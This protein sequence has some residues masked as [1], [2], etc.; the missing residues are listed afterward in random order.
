MTHGAYVCV[1]PRSAAEIPALVAWLGLHNEFG[2]NSRT[3]TYALLRR[4]SAK[5]ADIADDA[6]L[7]ADAIVHVE[8]PDAPRVE[9]F[10]AAFD[11]AR[12]L[13]GAIPPMQW[14][15]G[16]MFEYAYA[17]RVEQRPGAEM[18]NAF[19]LPLSKTADWWAKDWM[20]RHTYFLPRFDDGEM[21]AEGH[22]LAAREGVPALLRRTY[23]SDGEYDF[24]TYFECADRDIDTFF[25]VCDALRDVARNPEWEY[26]REGPLW[27]GVRVASVEEL[28]ANGGR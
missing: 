5:P 4:V 21:V 22:A 24:V 23:A 26:V 8:S 6:L 25:S 14:T 3:G 9:D 16:A 27:Q 12:V 2:P 28:W 17:H 15:G 10:C 20:E 19:L 11:D 1:D 18:P 13:R 7:N